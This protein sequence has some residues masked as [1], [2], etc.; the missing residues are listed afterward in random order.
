MAE[1]P[2]TEKIADFDPIGRE[3]VTKPLAQLLKVVQAADAA[4]T[5]RKEMLS[6]LFAVTE[7]CAASIG[8]WSLS[9]LVGY[10]AYGSAGSV[11]MIILASLIFLAVASRTETVLLSP[12][13]KETRHWT[14]YVS[15]FLLLTVLPIPAVRTF[16]RAVNTS[17]DRHFP[18]YGWASE[19][20]E[21]GR[22][23]FWLQLA[24]D[25]AWWDKEAVVVGNLEISIHNNKRTGPNG[26]NEQLIKDTA[27][28]RTELLHDIGLARDLMKFG[29]IGSFR[30]LLGRQQETLLRLTEGR[31]R[32]QNLIEEL[33]P[34]TTEETDALHEMKDGEH[35]AVRSWRKR[36]AIKDGN[37]PSR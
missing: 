21:D 13:L 9:A 27:A 26:L 2:K 34:A 5:A 20:A 4:N 3:E 30:R 7:R 12:V 19:L 32:I 24:E 29:P 16:Y 6:Q 23:A 25:I 15:N 35:G 28:A 17:M 36:R 11:L 8:G 37:D 22:F 1:H 33:R 31:P 10:L 14:D 18:G